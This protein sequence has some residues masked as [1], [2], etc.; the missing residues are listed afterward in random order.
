MFLI[1]NPKSTK[2]KAGG[3]VFCNYETINGRV[4]CVFEEARI[5]WGKLLNYIFLISYDAGMF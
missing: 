1:K 4:F 2:R 3:C 5:V